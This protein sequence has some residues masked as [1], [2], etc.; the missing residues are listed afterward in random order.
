MLGGNTYLEC[1]EWPRCW[2]IRCHRRAE[3]DRTSG[4]GVRVVEG[5]RRGRT[6]VKLVRFLFVC[7]VI[8]AIAG[9][10]L[11]GITIWYFGRDLPDYQQL[12]HYQPPITTR[13]H[14]GDGRL[15]AEYAAERRV[16]VPIQAIP[17]RL[18]TAF[19]SAEDKNFF[20]HH[21]IDPVSMV[22]AALTDVGRLRANRR[23]M[24]AST[25]TQQVAK[26][27]L[28]SNEISI[29]RKVKEV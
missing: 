7:G 12:A 26:N 29:E 8:L 23:P 1:L 15:L 19:L 27:M 13:V 14:A 2:R 17:K 21:G 22:R 4:L 6:M 5:G 3:L 25:I 11:V 9:S 20:S 16:F 18:V 24:G 28:L 10:G